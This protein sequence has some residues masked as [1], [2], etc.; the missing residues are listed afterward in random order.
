MNDL[1][2]SKSTFHH[3]WREIIMPKQYRV[4][5]IHLSNPFIINH[6]F[7]SDSIILQFTRLEKLTLH[8]IDLTSFENL[9]SHLISLPCLFS[10]SI[11]KYL[12]S[13]TFR[14]PP[15][16][17]IFRLPVLKYCKLS[18]DYYSTSGQLPIAMNEFSPIEHF[19][20]IN[21]HPLKDLNAILS[22]IP[23]LK[24]LS[25]HV[26]RSFTR[27]TV[28]QLDYSTSLMHLTHVSFNWLYI[29]FDQLE[30]MIQHLF[31]QA[32]VLRISTPLMRGYL[33]ADRWERLILYHMPH[34]G[35]FDIFV[36]CGPYDYDITAYIFSLNRFTS[37]FWF[38]RQWFFE[39]YYDIKANGSS[40]LKFCSVNP[41]R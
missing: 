5:S 7:A 24:H 3:C 1:S 20:L 36:S 17:Q 33:D 30:H 31:N 19:V 35:I 37:S 9:F 16:R 15:Y 8:G 12:I 14:I 6:I 39:C 25:I 29:P 10:L 21:K 22:Y 41:Y 18:V 13:T 2:A 26:R 40:F 11:T 28:Q 32:Q 23:H 27:F 34:L 4:Q 38:E